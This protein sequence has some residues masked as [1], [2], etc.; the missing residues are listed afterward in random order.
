[1]IAPFLKCVVV[2]SCFFVVAV[3]MPVN[4][5]SK[6]GQSSQV[7]VLYHTWLAF[8]ITV[9]VCVCRHLPQATTEWEDRLN[10][11]FQYPHYLMT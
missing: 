10:L 6:T 5:V 8:G 2:F 9:T 11:L 4:K 7:R 1:M 3:L